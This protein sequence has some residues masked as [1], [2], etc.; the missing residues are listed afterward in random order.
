MAPQ[1]GAL[2]REGGAGTAEGLA[3]LQAMAPTGE[4]ARRLFREGVYR[5]FTHGFAPGYVQ[6]NLAVLP[7]ALASDFLRFCQLNPKP[8]PLV[9]MSPTPGDPSMPELGSDLDIR[10]DVPLYRVWRKGELVAEVP[11]IR[12]FW[13]EDLVAFALGCS[14]SFEEAL[15]DDGLELRHQTCGVNVPM[16][17]TNIAC[18]PSGAFRGPMV[19]SMRPFKPAD[20]IRAVQITSRFPAVHGAPV[21]IGLPGMIGIEDINRPDYGDPVEVGRDELP[22]FWACGVTPQAVIAAIAPELAITHAP[23]AM[24]VTDVRNSRLAAL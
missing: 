13:R 1:D 2:A 11:D 9:G 22:V 15:V 17:R 6:A 24:L 14:F 4:A 16:F 8:C 23:G 18:Q 20:A 21:H 12:D 19:V 7:K 10:T 3:G 5:S